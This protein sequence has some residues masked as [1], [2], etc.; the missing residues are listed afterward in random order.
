MELRVK[1]LRDYLNKNNISTHGLV[2][3]SMHHSHII[4]D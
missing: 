4:Y 1:D 2:G 3:N